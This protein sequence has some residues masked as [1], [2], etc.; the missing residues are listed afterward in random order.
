M[1]STNTHVHLF[2]T[3]IWVL[4]YL[5]ILSLNLTLNLYF[6]FL[7]KRSWF[8]I[9]ALCGSSQSLHDSWNYSMPN[10]LH[11]LSNSCFTNKPIIWFT[12]YWQLKLLLRE[13]KKITQLHR[14]CSFDSEHWTENTLLVHTNRHHSSIWVDYRKWGN[15]PEYSQNQD[16]NTQTPNMKQEFRVCRSVRLHTFK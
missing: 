3:L 15:S 2:R 13:R 9:Y 14:S 8:Q 16:L 12:T 4:C 5:K 7:V 10:S 1:G 6:F 11:V